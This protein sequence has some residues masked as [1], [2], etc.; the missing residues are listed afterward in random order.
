M[1]YDTAGMERYEATVPP[2]Y[3]RHAKGVIF[4]YAIDSQE[5]IENIMH[6]A[7]SVSPH[8]LEFVGTHNAI[9]RFLVGNKTDLEDNRT[10]STKRGRDTADN[11][12]IDSTNFFEISAK[13]GAGFDECFQAIAR[14]CLSMGGTA[15]KGQRISDDERKPGK[16]RC[17]S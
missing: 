9:L 4:V 2:S 10:V 17:G 13:T 6:W 14:K 5:S 3:F 15:N 12:E 7:D 16:C 8:R 1:L 11:L